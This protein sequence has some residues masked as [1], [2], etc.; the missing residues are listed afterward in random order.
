MPLAIVLGA[1][2]L[3]VGLIVGAPLWRV[4]QRRRWAARPFPQSW[5]RILRRR[6]PLYRRLPADLQRQL[7]RAFA[8][9]AGNRDA[10]ASVK[11]ARA[12]LRACLCISS[13][14]AVRAHAQLSAD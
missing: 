13:G 11:L 4:R 6:M 1:A 8:A 9:G 2:L 10:F 7:R 14:Q 3:L 5:R 12:S